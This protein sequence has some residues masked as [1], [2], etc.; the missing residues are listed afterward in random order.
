[1]HIFH[2][3]RELRE[4]LRDR[5]E[6][7]I[8]FVPTMGALHVGHVSL[9]KLAFEHAENVGVSIFVNPTQFLPG[10]DYTKY[11]RP[12]END[13]AQLKAVGCDWV[14]V[15]SVEE[16]Y[17]IGSA[18]RVDPG[19]VG[20]ILEGT[21]RPGHFTGVA[22]VVIRLFELIQPDVAVFG[23]KDAQQCVVIQSV[24]RDLGNP[25]KIVI[26]NT[27]RE[28]DGLAYSSRNQYLSP[29]HRMRAKG[30][31]LSLREG[32]KVV[33]STARFP[34]GVQTMYKTMLQFQPTSIDYLTFVDGT[35]FGKSHSLV[36]CRA[37]GA[38]RFGNTR[39]IDNLSLTDV[40]SEL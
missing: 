17:P 1:M 20:T 34:V 15:P 18:T 33:A 7:P 36:T 5:R 8:G 28:K 35:T 11:P 24:V 40:A 13:L 9:V 19:H 29:E 32:L 39:L 25:V 12:L 4:Y 26:G 31:F 21:F 10:E 6:E 30:L 37:V 16:M 3:S 14:F 23:Q 22:T 38:V 27:L 2:T